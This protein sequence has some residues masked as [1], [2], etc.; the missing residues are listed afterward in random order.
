MKNPKNK[1]IKEKRREDRNK[2]ELIDDEK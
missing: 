2:L 1:K